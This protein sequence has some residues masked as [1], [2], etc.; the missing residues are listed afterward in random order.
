M[1]RANNVL[2]HHS[3]FNDRFSALSLF[4]MRVW[5]V[6]GASFAEANVQS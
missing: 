3:R 6:K 4:Y 1:N 5:S 2:T